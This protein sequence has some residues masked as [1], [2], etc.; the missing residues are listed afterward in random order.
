M[1][2][3]MSQRAARGKFVS[4]G[5]VSATRPVSA[6]SGVDRRERPVRII[7]AA[8]AVALVA[9][10][11]SACSDPAKSE[12]V[13]GAIPSEDV[14]SAPPGGLDEALVELPSLAQTMLD[15]SGVPGMAVA[16][17]QGDKT[18]FA[19]GF[20]VKTLGS[21]DPVDADTVFQIASVSKSLG[22]TVVA[23]QV[24]KGVVTWDTPVS[25]LMSGFELADPYI[26]DHAT[27]GDFYSHRS[28]LPPAA[29]DDLEDIGYDREY[30]LSHLV[31][32]PL[33]PFREVYNYS[34]FGMTVGGEAVAEAAGTSWE[35]L[36][37]RELYEPLGMT[38]TS[39]RYEDFLAQENRAT[40]HTKIGDSFAALYERDA[41][42]Q[43]P[44]GGVSSNVNDL[45]KWMQLILADGEFAGQ[46]LIDPSALLP[47]ISAQ[48]ISSHTTAPA[49][50]PAQY[51]FGFNVG[52]QPSGRVSLNHSGAF[53][54]GAATHF[55]MLPDADIG[56]IVLTNAGPVGAA[57]A[58]ASQ[59]MDLVQYGSIIRD[60]RTDYATLLA[61]YYLP[62]GD[63][64]G[65]APHGSPA[66]AAALD[67]YAGEYANEYFGPATVHV[68]D[69]GL[70]VDL[71]PADY[72][73]ALEHWDG[74]TFSFVPTGENAPYGSLSSA[75]FTMD[76][77]QAVAV[78]LEFFDT[79][80][81]G[82]WTRSAAQRQAHLP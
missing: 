11:A 19:D 17:V 18:V 54:L 8:A 44:A 63:L 5:V 43:S 60:W 40:I 9:V 12:I 49:Q 4:S 62:V 24:A 74:D 34:N 78:N 70:V 48:M 7:A 50:R 25:E 29:G 42:E 71:G 32:E 10:G 72:R 57:E 59:F 66:P 61:H 77:D 28:G 65:E 20:G 30:V 53:V 76:G 45:A 81:L 79:N 35:D 52:V 1:N 22:A 51:G 55:Q 33:V 13:T 15:E 56:I 31:Y 69:G 39:S 82:T 27:V 21:D 38:S 14:L 46:Q 36:S 73:L 41:D 23:T 58:L 6:S 80:G 68:V 75:T 37:E 64:V 2:V 47:A 26:A 16:V 67:A 3:D